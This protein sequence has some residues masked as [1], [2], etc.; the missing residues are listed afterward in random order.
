MFE[1]HFMQNKKLQRLT[2]LYKTILK[3]PVYIHLF[4]SLIF[5]LYHGSLNYGG[6]KSMQYSLETHKHL[7][8][9]GRPSQILPDRKPG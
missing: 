5:H 7:H 1:Y 3:Q 2:H 4:A 6:K 8:V 9:A